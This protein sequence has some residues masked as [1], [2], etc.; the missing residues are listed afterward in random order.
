L[1]QH[2]AAAI[3]WLRQ[4]NK[5]HYVKIAAQLIP[6]E[7][8]MKDQSI[9]DLSDEQISQMIEALSDSIGKNAKVVDAE[10]TD[11]SS[12]GQEQD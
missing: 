4:H 1:G 6:K 3:A 12:V 7:F 8:V 9:K 10:V 11:L 2:G 5:L